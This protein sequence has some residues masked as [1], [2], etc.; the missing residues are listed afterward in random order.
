MVVIQSELYYFLNHRENKIS[1]LFK[2]SQEKKKWGKMPQGMCEQFSLEGN[3][4]VS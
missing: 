1:S 3:T 2:H 4:C